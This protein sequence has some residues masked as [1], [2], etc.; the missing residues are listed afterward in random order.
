MLAFILIGLF[1]LLRL[2]GDP[3][4]YNIF[5]YQRLFKQKKRNKKK[6]YA[7]KFT[8]HWATLNL[9]ASYFAA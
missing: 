1:P 7:T 2:V 6:E 4:E 8:D 5:V 3:C 9:H